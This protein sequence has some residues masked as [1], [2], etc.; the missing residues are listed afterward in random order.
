MDEKEFIDAVFMD[1][2][3][4]VMLAALKDA[5]SELLQFEVTLPEV[6]AA[7]AQAERAGIKE[8]RHG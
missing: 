2:T 7:I 4:E 1:M 8:Y 5:R 6:E 3:A